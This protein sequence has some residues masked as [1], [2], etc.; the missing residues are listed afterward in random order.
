MAGCSGSARAQPVVSPLVLV[1]P[2]STPGRG[3]PQRDIAGRL[4]PSQEASSDER[5][6]LAGQGTNSGKKMAFK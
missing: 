2:V 3:W 1:A 4:A 6:A 5:L